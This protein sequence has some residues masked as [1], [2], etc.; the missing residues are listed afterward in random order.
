VGAVDDAVLDAAL[1][2]VGKAGQVT[3]TALGPGSFRHHPSPAIAY[4]RRI[5]GGVLGGCNPLDDIPRLVRAYRDGRLDV[6]GLVT[7]RY[8]LDDIDDGFA[9]LHA[10]RNLRGVIAHE[11]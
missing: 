11:W 1:L 7:A 9:D 2:V 3:V 10:G 4:T 8:R 6:D 5:R